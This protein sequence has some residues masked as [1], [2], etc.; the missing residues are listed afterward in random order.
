VCGHKTLQP[1][2]P[3]LEFLGFK[4]CGKIVFVLITD[5]KSIASVAIVVA[6]VVVV[7]DVVDVVVVVVGVTGSISLRSKRFNLY[8]V[9]I[10][11]CSRYYTVRLKCFGQTTGV[12]NLNARA[13]LDKDH[14]FDFFCFLNGQSKNSNFSSSEKLDRLTKY[15]FLSS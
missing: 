1:L 15:H 12:Y 2:S 13:C 9:S 7:D 14:K 6:V 11:F 8:R 10:C 5:C 3:K 4:Q